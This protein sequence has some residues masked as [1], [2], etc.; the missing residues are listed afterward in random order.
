MQHAAAAFGLKSTVLWIGTS[1]KVFGYDI[2]SNIIANP[3]L[4]NTKLISSY[5]FDYALSG[6]H[7]ECPYSDIMDIFDTK[8]I[9]ESVIKN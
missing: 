8:A 3:P 9:I 4:G 5:L 6:A 2:H 7:Q 1:P